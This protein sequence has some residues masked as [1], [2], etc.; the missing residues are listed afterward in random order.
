MRAKEEALELVNK[1]ANKSDEFQEGTTWEY[2]IKCALISIESTIK[3][4]ENNQWQNK[5]I[6]DHYKEVKQEINKL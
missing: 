1:F 2:D 6:I 4:L 5:T 3:A